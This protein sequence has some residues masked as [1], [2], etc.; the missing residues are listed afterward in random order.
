VTI[1]TSHALSEK[2]A[3]IPKP[4]VSI[5]RAVSRHGRDGWKSACAIVRDSTQTTEQIVSGIG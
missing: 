1:V 3:P 4:N 5:G 2:F